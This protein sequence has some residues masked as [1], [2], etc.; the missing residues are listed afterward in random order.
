MFRCYGAKV[1]IMMDLRKRILLIA[2]VVIGVI[3]IILLAYYFL[4]KED[5]VDDFEPV[6]GL[7]TETVPT[8]PVSQPTTGG[9]GSVTNGTVTEMAPVD[10]DE[11]YAKQVSRIFVERFLSYSNQNDN[12]HIAEVLPMITKSMAAWAE[13]QTIE[14][15]EDYQGITTKLIASQ[16]EE[17]DEEKAIVSIDV[18]QVFSSN[19]VQNTEYK[20]GRVNLERD[21]DDWLVAGLYWE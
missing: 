9:T 2:G 16:V 17:I 5:L 21:G 19:G 12:Q 20:S 13:K 14:Q 4:P 10:P 15:S 6:S 1:N 7:P 8:T 18:Q 3:A 11:L